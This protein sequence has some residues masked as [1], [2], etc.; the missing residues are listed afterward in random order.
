MNTNVLEFDGQ[1]VVVTGAAT[2]IGE[3]CTRLFARRGAIVT[4]MDFDGEGAERVAVEM[5]AW[6]DEH[7]THVP[8]PVKDDE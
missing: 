3:A 8:S 6:Q 7:G 4:L 2:G 5:R 1:S